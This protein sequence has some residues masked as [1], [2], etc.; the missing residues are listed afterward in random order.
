MTFNFSVEDKFDELPPRIQAYL[1]T[2]FKNR[3][4]DFLWFE[5]ALK[6]QNF[7]EI[8]DYCHKQ[9]GV[10]TCYNSYKLHEVVRHIQI[11]AR[12]ENFAEVKS[13]YIS[14]R[15]YLIECKKRI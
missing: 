3:W 6:D 4:E 14:L 8:R 1:P 10:A 11:H 13:A 15:D 9:I 2:F 12:A 5:S 7:K